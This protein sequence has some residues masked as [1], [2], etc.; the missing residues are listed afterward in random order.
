MSSSLNIQVA[1]SHPYVPTSHYLE[2]PLFALMQIEPQAI[3]GLTLRP[4]LNL[5]VVVDSSATMH[6]FQLT[7]EEMDY[8]TGVAISRDE[9]EQGEAD[10]SHAIYWT[11]QTLSEMQS[12]VT[13]PMAMAVE[14]IKNLMTELRTTDKIA[15]IAFADHVHTVFTEQDWAHFPDQSLH[16]MD[17]LRE[18]RLPVDIG[19]GTQMSQA[20]RL[21]VKSLQSSADNTGINRLIVISDG[22][23]QDQEETLT[24]I[25]EIQ[26]LGYAITTIGVGN[27]FDEEFLMQVAD[28]SRGEY[29]Y[30]GDIAEITDRI[31]QEMTT[32]QAATMKDMYIAVRGLEGAVVQ[33]LFL[34]RPAMT[35]FDELYTE[36]GWQRAR[37]GDVSS[38]APTAVMVQIAPPNA[39]EGVRTLVE[40]RLTW[41]FTHESGTEQGNEQINITATYTDAPQL[42]LESNAEIGDLVSRFAVYKLERD[43]QRAQERGDLPMAREKL[44]A[45]T[46]QL[47]SLG[48][49]ELA[50]DIEGQLAALGAPDGNSSRVKRI[51]ATTRRLGNIS[52]NKLKGDV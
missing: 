19:T 27:E 8:W 12:I 22:I 35:I 43:A 46:R 51:K 42:L 20:L 18:Q 29:H 28:N 32:L 49:E 36:D 25:A 24:A 31:H 26:A 11:G 47:H 30:A 38:A 17:A 13:T 40:T 34:V 39:P 9:R 52:D 41:T 1:L 44:G 2:D 4:P 23:V 15:V 16:Q 10:E 14:A 7:E 37:L 3:A 50:Q 48:E 33:D 6:H 5:V 21:A 45:A